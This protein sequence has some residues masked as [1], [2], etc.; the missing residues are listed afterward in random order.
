MAVRTILVA[1]AALVLSAG[2]Q[3]TPTVSHRRLIEHQALIDFS[4]LKPVEAVDCV[5]VRAGVPRQW[6]RLEL[7][8]NALYTHQ[9]WR[10]P[11]G[12]TGI[13]VAH[14]RLP[15]PMGIGMLKWLAKR[16]YTKKAPDGSGGGRIIAEWGDDLGRPWFE[17]ENAR[18]HVRGYVVARGFEAWVIYFGHKSK[19]PPD[20][21]ELTL[22]ARAVE[23]IVPNLGGKS[24]PL[25]R[26]PQRVATAAP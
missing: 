11:S 7:Q 22:A 19:S 17:A 5:K 18:Y 4:G 14:V 26:S 20:P 25:A 16:E 9:Q 10:S 13:G 1:A 15:L 8:S 21:A 3:Q 23:T 12:K 24:A 6:E 2:C